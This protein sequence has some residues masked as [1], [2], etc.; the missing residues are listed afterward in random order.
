MNPQ[1]L[2]LVD[3]RLDDATLAN[4]LNRLL[5]TATAVCVQ[6]AYLRESG[7]ALLRD[8]FAGFIADGGRLRVLAGGDFAQ[9][10]PNALQFFRQ[11]GG[12]CE[13]RLVSSSGIAGFHPKCYLVYAGET[14]TLVVGSSNFTDGGLQKNVE[15]NLKA[16]LAADDPTVQAAQRIFDELWEQTPLLTDERL[17]DYTR[18]WEQCQRSAA[19]FIYRLPQQQ[20]EETAMPEYIDP[21]ELK[22]GD[23]V[24][25]NGQEG[26]VIATTKLG[27]RWSVRLAVEGLGTRTLLSPP[28]QFQRVDTPASRAK[29]FDF[30]TPVE[31]DLLTEATRL[32]L[33]YEHDRLVSLSNSRTKLEPY[34][35]AA[36][37][38]VAAA[39]EQRFLIADDVGLG[40]TVE[41]GMIVKE[42]KAR[43]RAEKV[44]IICPAGLALQW[45]R[46]MREKFDERF[47]LLKSGELRQWRS[48]RPAGEP[49]SQRYPHAIVSI[50]V[51]KPRD[52][53]NCSPD[54][55]EAHWDVVIIDEAHKVAQHG[56]GQELIA[57]YKLARDIAPSCDSLLLLS[58]TPHD[59]DPFAFHSLLGLLDPL[60]FP[61]PDD[62]K[63]TELQPIMV[64]RNKAD[65][66]KD[67][68]TPLFPPRWVDTTEVE[69]T[70][71]ELRLYNE[72]TDYVRE[73][74]RA[75]TELK[76]N[77]VGFL[78]VLLQKRMVS[79][80]A[81]IRRSLER[82][83][84]ALEH[85][86]AAA[87]TPSELR[88]LKDREADEESLTD[89][90]REELQGK[91]EAAR[92]KLSTAQQQHEIKRVRHLVELAKGIKVDS[93]AQELR[94]FVEGV[95]KKAPHEKILVFTEYTDT[96]D[97]LRDDVLKGLGPIAQIHGSM[98]M[99]ER[100]E[101][102]E[103]FQKPEVH[104]MVA[105]DAAGEGLNL[106]FCHLMINYE[107]PWNP[108]RIEQRI[109]RLHRY[110]QEHDVRV[111]NL[112]VVNTRE[113]IILARLLHK[114]KTIEQQL[115]GY[116]PNILGLTAPSEAVDLERLS[117]LIVNAIAEDT[118]PEVTAKHIESVVEARRQMYEQLESTLFMPLHRFD[119]GQADK[120]IEDSRRLT[121]SNTD[122][123]AFV[124]QYFETY[125]GK[126]ENTKF[127]NVFRLRTPRRLL[128]GKTVLDEYPQATF[129]KATA[130]KHKARDV[131]FVAFGHPLL[132]AIIRD[133]RSRTPKL[134][135]AASVKR[136]SA[137]R[138]G[139]P[140]GIL[141]NYLLR[142]SDAQDNTLSEELL[143][144]FVTV[145]GKVN[146]DCGPELL[147]AKG[148]GVSRPPDDLQLQ[149]IVANWEGCET[150]AQE[151]AAKAAQKRFERV[152][153]KRDR[154]A[155]ASL[156]SLDAFQKAKANRLKGTLQNYQLRLF[157]GEDMDISIRRAQYELEQIE[158]DC[159]RRRQQIE[160]R[161]QVQAN[162]PCLLNVGILV[163]E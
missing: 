132:Q 72:V 43:H 50:D 102:E 114:L 11:L 151:A 121:P 17:A 65:I 89:A 7:V 75:A 94:A 117:D 143:P 128:D 14:A 112:Q 126:I 109:G 149:E 77:A 85:P 46:V 44:L 110:G 52:D 122:I 45:H 47:E 131:Q 133:C 33:A 138:L 96:L 58:A 160:A 86:E 101:Q 97:Y 78:M 34:Q 5:T 79:S 148:E 91:L 116:A 20:R 31:F 6:V 10:E 150:I 147:G 98:D 56:Q 152:R 153:E 29:R 66:R 142:Y 18:F 105:T 124:R 156:Y 140:C 30:D 99:E 90:R 127:K 154:Q 118:P 74:Y 83:L 28:T 68:G 24:Q 88:E 70:A 111:Y 64:R 16:E 12:D 59:G 145:K 76:E 63:P 123:E 51:A 9:T 55:T 120:L 104:L 155:D 100:Q 60:R 61:S 21:A 92:L 36:V 19:G 163:T 73:G 69:F 13:V 27:D 62:I 137:Q 37:H 81:A 158:A 15:L 67:D 107:L 146:L 161:R 162:A 54:F 82:R 125:E 39:W 106:Q 1:T 48:T 2:Q 115:G 23:I 8:S 87:L 129:D 119:K 22:A 130:F 139:A 49:L 113:G 157:E 80:I 71:D 135:G 53:E 144:V 159:A 108:N 4:H 136:V 42:L 35:V 38:K 103:F 3:N 40:K 95:F 84:M 57:R 93:K 25:F 32:S 41:T 134:R 26:E 141:F